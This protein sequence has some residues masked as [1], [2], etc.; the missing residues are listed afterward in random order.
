MPISV[1]KNLLAS[2]TGCW[3]S[4]YFIVSKEELK[5]K[6][7]FYQVTQVSVYN[8]NA[9]KVDVRVTFHYEQSSRFE[10]S[11]KIFGGLAATKVVGYR[12]CM[13]NMDFAI[14]PETEPCQV[15]RIA[16]YSPLPIYAC[17]QINMFQEGRS[18]TPQPYFF[19]H[20]SYP[21]TFHPNFTADPN[22]DLHQLTI[23]PG[24]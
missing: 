15:G 21:L 14:F 5:E 11:L 19:D 8:P 18:N 13:S 10:F 2:E 1:K 23:V 22:F 6:S 17:G 16:V 12:N 3:L 9:T 4:P 20:R 7:V 24:A